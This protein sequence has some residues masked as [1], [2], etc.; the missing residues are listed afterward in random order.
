MWVPS[1]D[2]EAAFAL[3]A[4]SSRQD[5]QLAGLMLAGS[6]SSLECKL[7]LQGKEAEVTFRSS[8]PVHVQAG[9]VNVEAMT[10]DGAGE[11][12]GA[13]ESGDGRGRWRRLRWGL[14]RGT[15]KQLPRLSVTY[16]TDESKTARPVR[17]EQVLPMWAPEARQ[18]VIATPTP[19]RTD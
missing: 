12:C 17:L 5:E 1:L 3:L 4:G 14:A 9:K 16:T 7:D 18:P 19:P 15:E 13:G 10:A 11:I 6:L 8:R 2:I